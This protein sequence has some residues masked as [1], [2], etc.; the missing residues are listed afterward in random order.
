[1]NIESEILEVEERS[2]SSGSPVPALP[3]L[4]P[5]TKGAKPIR[6]NVVHSTPQR[7]IL[8]KSLTSVYKT[9]SSITDNDAQA[10][11]PSPLIQKHKNNP[12]TF[13]QPKHSTISSPADVYNFNFDDDPDRLGE[14]QNRENNS[15]VDSSRMSIGAWFD[16]TYGTLYKKYMRGERSQ[17]GTQGMEE[18]EVKDD[19]SQSKE[20]QI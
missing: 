8:R 5:K 3:M 16:D 10:L 17:F 7:V 18:V 12:E 4:P 13:L 20:S 1:M 11:A 2:G 19:E 6:K 14:F 9:Q 15:S